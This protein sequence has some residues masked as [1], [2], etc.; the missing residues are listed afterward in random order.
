MIPQ[1]PKSLREAPLLCR[2]GVSRY[3][4]FLRQ[5]LRIRRSVAE[6]GIREMT[7]VAWDRSEKI[8]RIHQNRF[9][10]LQSLTLPYRQVLAL[11]V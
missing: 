2:A 7:T 5:S 6:F 1:N 3:F 10:K 8:Q 11:G 9:G 4:D